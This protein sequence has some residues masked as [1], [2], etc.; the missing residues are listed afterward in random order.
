IHKTPAPTTNNTLSLHDALPIYQKKSAEA[1]TKAEADL[2]PKD[3][4]AKKVATEKADAEKLLAQAGAAKTKAEEAKKTADELL[5][6]ADE[7]IKSVK[8]GRDLASGI[9]SEAGKAAKTATEKAISDLEA[10]RTLLEPQRRAAE[11]S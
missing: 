3:E 6:K 9:D 1:L 10:L 2:K 5:A 11:D 4:A 7:A 8:A